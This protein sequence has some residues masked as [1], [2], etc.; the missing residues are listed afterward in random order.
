M[1]ILI[2]NLNRYQANEVNILLTMD[3][4]AIFI[5]MHLKITLWHITATKKLRDYSSS[6]SEEMKALII[7]IC[8]KINSINERT[9]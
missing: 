9:K 7:L 4:T 8:M 6:L 3:K 5:V 1:V 2:G